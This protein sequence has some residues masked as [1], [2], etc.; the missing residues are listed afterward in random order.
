MNRI[1]AVEYGSATPLQKALFGVA[2]HAG[3]SLLVQMMVNARRVA[4]VG[5]ADAL[6]VG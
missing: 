2:C 6:V 3:S 5:P 1:A 4:I